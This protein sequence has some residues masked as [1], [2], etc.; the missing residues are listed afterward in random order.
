MT[1]PNARE[2]EVP[3]DKVVRYL[4]NLSHEDG[5]GKAIFF[6]NRR[7][8]ASDWEQLA[9]ALRQHV[10]TND[11]AS[12]EPHTWGTKY[13]VD[14]PLMCPDGSTPNVRSVWNIKPPATHPR[15]V[16]SYPLK[17]DEAGAG[18]R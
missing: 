13:V 18:G 11:A 10:L 7:F 8:S 16:T 1:T 3:E 15:F 4:L 6:L 14:G 2:A 9:E 5:R 12:V 17:P